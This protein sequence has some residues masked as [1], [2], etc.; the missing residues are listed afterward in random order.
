[1]GSQ[2]SKF[3]APQ[4]QRRPH[5]RRYVLPFEVV[6]ARLNDRPV[7]SRHLGQAHQECEDPHTWYDYLESALKQARGDLPTLQ[8]E[9]IYNLSAKISQVDEDTLIGSV[10]WIAPVVG[11]QLLQEAINWCVGDRMA[12]Y[13]L[14]DETQGWW[15]LVKPGRVRLSMPQLDDFPLEIRGLAEWRARVL[16][17]EDPPLKTPE[18]GAAA[19]PAATVPP[20]H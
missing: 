11:E 10:T 19:A 8:D 5:L 13:G 15:G 2:A 7:R 4:P 12:Q 16:S 3:P 6:V 1:M 20:I 9:Q 14:Q 17:P 18:F